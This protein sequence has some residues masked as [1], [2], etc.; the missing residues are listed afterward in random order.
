[1][2]PGEDPDLVHGAAGPLAELQ[3]WKEKG[4][5]RY[6]GAS[7]HDR[8]VSRRLAED[9]RVDVLMQRYNMAHRAAAEEV[10]PTCRRNGVALVTFTATRWGT[11]LCGHARWTGAAPGA[12]DCYRFCLAHPGVDVTL[13]APANATELDEDLEV[14]SHAPMTGRQIEHWKRYGDLV[15]GDG[16]DSFETEWP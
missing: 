10:F 8:L 16:T 12:V 1:V 7:A 6:V 11:L 9:P 13:A 15:Y 3:T 5:I 2:H 4:L 14:L